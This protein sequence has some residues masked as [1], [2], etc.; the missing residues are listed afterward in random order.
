MKIVNGVVQV[1]AFMQYMT[2]PRYICF[3]TTIVSNDV[4]LRKAAKQNQQIKTFHVSYVSYVQSDTPC[5]FLSVK[6]HMTS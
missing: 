3:A 2:P 6:P 1:S 4:G 5:L